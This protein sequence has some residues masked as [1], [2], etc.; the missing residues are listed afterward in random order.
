MAFAF[1]TQAAAAIENARLYVEVRRRAD[2][3]AA[4]SSVSDT[5]SQSLD[6]E[7]TLTTALDKALEVVGF[8]AG[9]ISLVDEEAQELI[10]RVHRGWRQQDLAS[11]MHLRLG[12]GLSGQAVV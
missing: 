1:A 11:N 3:L 10:I 12:Q 6:L 8:E 7:T 2:H 5:V 9:A 4:L